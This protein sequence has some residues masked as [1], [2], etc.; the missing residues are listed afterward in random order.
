MDA[1][2]VMKRREFKFILT[3]EQLAFLKQSLE[4]HMD[5][6]QYGKTTI[7]SLYYDTPDF[8]LIRASIERPAFKEKIRL[9]SYGLNDNHRP[10]FLELKRKNQGIVYKRRIVLRE[11]DAVSFLNGDNCLED[12]QI[13]KEITYFRDYY[14][15]LV[16]QI[17]IMYDR[18]AYAD[19]T[20]LRLTID[21]NP[22]YR[23]YGLNMNSSSNGMLLLPHG[24]AILE[25]KA[26]EEIPLWL[27]EILSQG[28]IYKTTFSK[29]GE[30][31][32]QIKQRQFV[33]NGLER[34]Q[35]YEISI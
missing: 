14:H 24:S 15:K 32:K 25:I 20:D 6:D 22:R 11:E 13:S 16:P 21:E 8:R 31:Y 23:T 4:G 26:Q 19:N 12:N 1:I 18:T 3:K 17:M 9:R 2:T 35:S 5:V 7:F 30:A 10:V 34:R 28:K 33:L 27:V 29:V